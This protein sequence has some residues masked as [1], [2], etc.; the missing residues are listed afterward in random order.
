L[1]DENGNYLLLEI[2]FPTGFSGL[3]DVC[4]VDIPEK[5]IAYLKDKAQRQ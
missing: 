1:E 2:N 5:M 4:G 3:I